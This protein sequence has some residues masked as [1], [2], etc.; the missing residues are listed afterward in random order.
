MRVTWYPV[1]QVPVSYAPH[2]AA[3][4]CLCGRCQQAAA[5]SRAAAEAESAAAAAEA[6]ARP[7]ADS[8]P[9]P[10]PTSASA[11]SAGAG[12]GI[13]QGVNGGEAAHEGA[14]NRGSAGR[15]FAAVDA[16]IT[17]SRLRFARQSP[18]RA[19]APAPPPGGQRWA[20]PPQPR[21]AQ[22]TPIAP[23]HTSS[24]LARHRGRSQ[25]ETQ[26]ASFPLGASQPPSDGPGGW[27]PAGPQQR[28]SARGGPHVAEDPSNGWRR[29]SLDAEEDAANAAFA[30]MH[31][32][33]PATSVSAAA[34]ALAE[35]SAVPGY[36]DNSEQGFDPWASSTFG[37]PL[38]G[39][40]AGAVPGRE[41][42]RSAGFAPPGRNGSQRPPDFGEVQFPE[43]GTEAKKLRDM[44]FDDDDAV[45]WALGRT[46][47][48]VAQA[49]ELLLS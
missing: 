20:A 18:N 47:G 19:G 44:G 45:Q 34:G 12:S 27:S 30:W 38:P 5:D 1:C 35:P 24:G 39:A 17:D 41:A 40:P 49:L 11:G 32:A 48:N 2:S 29:D 9:I 4:P 21:Y 16:P 13:R 33:R 15:L 46:G 23:Q 8:R 43:W 10:Q 7:A 31:R 6:A 14:E 25:S 28:D 42:E 26:E 36:R 37:V 22:G 3:E